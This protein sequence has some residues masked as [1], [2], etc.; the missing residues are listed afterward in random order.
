MVI[1][2]PKLANPTVGEGRL[3]TGKR[4]SGNLP[5][6]RA[7]RKLRRDVLRGIG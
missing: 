6:L 2:K 4:N 7:R 3:K 1:N 5:Y